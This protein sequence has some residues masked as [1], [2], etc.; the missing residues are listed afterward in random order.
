LFAGRHALKEK[1]RERERE[2]EGKRGRE[3]EREVETFKVTEFMRT[4]G[5]RSPVGTS[6]L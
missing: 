2:G 3:R 6:L 5:A 1:E 4:R